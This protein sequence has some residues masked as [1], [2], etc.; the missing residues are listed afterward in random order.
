MRFSIKSSYFIQL[1]NII[2]SNKNSITL[3][4]SSTNLLVYRAFIYAAID[5]SRRSTY[6][7][8]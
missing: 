1:I 4:I 5:N 3:L 2:Y 8:H 6:L 7:E